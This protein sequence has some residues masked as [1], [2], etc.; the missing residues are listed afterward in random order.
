MVDV[1]LGV[2]DAEAVEHLLVR[3][4]AE[5]G[6]GEH[7]GLAAGEE[8]RAVGAGQNADLDCDGADVLGAATVGALAA[9]ENGAANFLLE[10]GIEGLVHISSVSWPYRLRR[11]Q[12]R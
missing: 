1:A 11:G 8:G 10:E 9:L 6:D 4:C 5:G 2:L 12:A 7:L 3:A